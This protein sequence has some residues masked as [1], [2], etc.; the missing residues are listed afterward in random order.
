MA[1]LGFLTGDVEAKYEVIL[2]LSLVGVSCFA[3]IG[4]S[5]FSISSMTPSTRV[6]CTKPK[7][8]ISR[9]LPPS[10]RVAKLTSWFNS[11]HYRI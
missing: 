10:R 1:V 7:T 2:P 11:L 5:R 8:G 3:S 4:S 6:P 9:A